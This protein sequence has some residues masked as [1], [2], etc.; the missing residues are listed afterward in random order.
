[1]QRTSQALAAF[2]LL[3]A[4]GLPTA[5]ALQGQGAT[6]TQ[7][8]QQTQPETQPET[9]PKA[10]TPAPPRQPRPPRELP[11]PQAPAPAPAA[12]AKPGE[13]AKPIVSER[14]AAAPKAP[15][16]KEGSL[17]QRSERSEDVILTFSV[18]IKLETRD[19]KVETRVDP[20]TG[21][22]TVVAKPNEEKLSTPIQSLSLMLPYPVRTG[23]ST[24]LGKVLPW[25]EQFTGEYGYKARLQ[26][27]DILVDFDPEILS[28]RAAGG[29]KGYPG[30][31]QLAKLVYLP[32]G[33]A[34][35]PTVEATAE[36]AMR[37]HDTI[38]D[39]KAALAVAWPTMW[40]DECSSALLPQLWLQ[41]GP[42]PE[43]A[44]AIE[45]YKPEP[46]ADAIKAY[47]AEE[48]IS[49]VKEVTPVA[50]AKLLTSKVWRDIQPT[51]DG[52]ER[53]TAG[54][55]RKSER[56]TSSITGYGIQ[57]PALTLSSG[58]GSPF[59]I[60][61]LL[62]ALMQQAG[63]PAR[64]IIGVDT[65]G[66]G[67]GYSRDARGREQLRVWLEF[68]VYDQASNTLNWVPV[69][70]VRLRSQTQ[71]PA[72]LDVP[73]KFF[74]THDELRRVAPLALSFSPPTDVAIYGGA[75]PW[76]WFVTPKSPE[77]IDSRISYNVRALPKRSG[78][79][80]QPADA[81]GMSEDEKRSNPANKPA[82]KPAEKKKKL[83]E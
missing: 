75:S 44:N 10:P 43:K 33:P 78:D 2:V 83:G 77:F 66:D 13:R 63:L 32:E 67:Q 12:P 5:I 59:D 47:L 35:P 81:P 50:L 15:I 19:T 51:G 11:K 65:V 40:P 18:A 57:P 8:E 54:G 3:A 60:V 76:G 36:I 31:A 21:K 4:A 82:N 61:A 72:K 9:Q 30:G 7:P 34:M 70:I 22:P 45:E 74:G 58:K 52:L 1:M 20:K 56:R 23:S 80:P 29:G 27:N 64:P 41:R 55:D 62:T 46:L 24:A 73:W 69:D 14:P 71:R 17:V 49:D 28:G 42:N 37:T 26:V 16:A 79:Q 68:A 48:G 38:F 6:Q 25:D 39:E 53:S